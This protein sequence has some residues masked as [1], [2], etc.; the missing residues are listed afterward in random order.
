[1]RVALIG[2]G[3]QARRRAPV[4]VNSR[5]DSLDFVASSDATRARDFARNHGCPNWGDWRAAVA[6]DDIDAFLVCTTPETHA[7]ITI[8]ALRSGKHVLCEKP[9][10]RTVPEAEAMVGAARQAGRILKCGFNHRH[11]PALIK[12]KATIESGQLGRL[13]FGRA[14]Y[15]ICG[16]PDYQ[17]EW[18]GNPEKAAG[19]QLMELGIHVIDLFRGYFGDFDEVACMAGALFFPI[20]PLDDNGM[21]ILRT[22]AGALCSLHSSLTQW[23]NLFSFE[24]FGAEGYLV[25]E[26]LGASYGTQTISIGR[27]DYVAPFEDVVTEYRGADRSWQLEW[28]EFAAAIREGRQPLGNGQDGLEALRITLAAYEAA[29]QRRNIS[30]PAGAPVDR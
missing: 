5:T 30:L 27:K 10:S 4:I 11:H 28:E 19:G 16:R 6:R 7:E 2:T 25:V 24:V 15:G 14:R 3:L 26:G 9:L 17:N 20:Q 12:A 23:K 22:R 13:I 29:E 18:R 1:M 21:I 8:A